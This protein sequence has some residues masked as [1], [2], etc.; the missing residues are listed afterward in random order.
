[1]VDFSS[2]LVMRGVL[3]GFLQV[4]VMMLV[5]LDILLAL[6]FLCGGLVFCFSQEQVFGFGGV[7]FGQF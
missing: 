7:G 4:I 1:M 3:L 2:V 5:N 6:A